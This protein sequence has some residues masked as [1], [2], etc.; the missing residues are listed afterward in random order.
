MLLGEED[1]NKLST[2]STT[3]KDVA[4]NRWSAGYI[5]YCVQQGILAGTGNGQ[6][7]PEAS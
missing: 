7:R 2:N 4:A 3:F 6:L 1:A 5:G